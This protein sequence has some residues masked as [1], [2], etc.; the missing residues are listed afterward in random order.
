MIAPDSSRVRAAFTLIELLVVIALMAIL[1]TLI[2]VSAKVVLAHSSQS[3]GLSNMRQVA[4]GFQLYATDNDGRLPSRV[5]DVEH[6]GDKWPKL[7][8]RY[9]K[10]VRVYADPGDTENYLVTKNPKLQDPL[11]NTANNTSYIANGWNDLTMPDGGDP[12]AVKGPPVDVYMS[13]IPTL[14]DTVLLGN[15]ISGL[16][17]FYM[18]IDEGGGNQYTDLDLK[19]YGDGSN[20]VFVDGSARYITEKAYKADANGNG[21]R[22]GDEM[23]LSDKTKL[24]RLQPEP[25]PK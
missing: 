23:W 24:D 14:G 10:D 4:T 5:M 2:L 8:A 9:L 15:P 22:D 19:L 13:N 16:T 20:Y 12:N 21:K 1:A 6:D 25:P 7:I 18:D 11:S 17:S 3:K